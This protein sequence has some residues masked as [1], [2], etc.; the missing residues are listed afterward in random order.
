MAAAPCII[1]S[2]Y[3]GVVICT[4][5]RTR[6]SR[7]QVFSES[8][9]AGAANSLI[10]AEWHK[11]GL[12]FHINAG[13]HQGREGNIILIIPGIRVSTCRKRLLHH[14]YRERL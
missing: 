2:L 5:Y 1:L 4:Q 10:G 6:G 3:T 7:R 11:A 13:M 14:L 12:D 9:S 8:V